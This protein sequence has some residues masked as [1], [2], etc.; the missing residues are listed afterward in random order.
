MKKL[1]LIFISSF[2]MITLTEG[3]DWANLK[4]Y[5]EANRKIDLPK[6]DEH[7]VVF[8]GNSITEGWLAIDPDFFKD[9]PYLNRGISG[10]TT[11]QMLVRFRQDVIG[12]KP[13]VVAILAGTNDIAGNTGPT[14]LEE[15]M[16]NI[17]S[18]AELAKANTI[19]VI[20]CSVMPVFDYPWRPGLKPATKIIELNK[21][22]QNYCVQ[23]NL[24]YVDFYSSM[25]NDQGGL[26]YELGEDGVH[27]NKKGYVVIEPLIEKA[28]T[29]ALSKN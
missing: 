5:E 28:I 26:K 10:Q 14:T 3:Q 23:N 12:L 29:E 25:V 15:I 20:L 7:R 24:I 8:M 16:G 27:P 22:I 1:S 21:M 13:E 17:A 4:K 6:A 11:P 2:F 18:M 9:K 19:K